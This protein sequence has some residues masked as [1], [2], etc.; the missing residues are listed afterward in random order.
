MRLD[1]GQFTCDFCSTI[2]A[3]D[4]H[5]MTDRYTLP[6]APC[7]VL[8]FHM[9]RDNIDYPLRASPGAAGFDVE[10]PDTVILP[11]CGVTTYVPLGFRCDAIPTG[12]CLLMMGRSRMVRQQ[13]S[14]LV[15]GV[16]DNDYREEVFAM[17]TNLGA[18]DVT[19]SAGKKLIQMLL[20]PVVTRNGRYNG[21][22]RISF[23]HAAI[24]EE[25]ADDDARSDGGTTVDMVIVEDTPVI[26]VYDTT[27]DNEVKIINEEA[28][29]VNEVKEDDDIDRPAVVTVV[30]SDEEK[31][32]DE[33]DYFIEALDPDCDDGQAERDYAAWC[34]G[35][36]KESVDIANDMDKLHVELAPGGAAKANAAEDEM[37]RCELIHLKAR[38]DE[39]KK[40][41]AVILARKRH[42]AR[43]LRMSCRM[44][45][46]AAMAVKTGASSSSSSS[47]SSPKPSSS[48]TTMETDLI[49]MHKETPQ[50]PDVTCASAHAQLPKTLKQ[51]WDAPMF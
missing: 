23:D 36:M 6:S 27:N 4:D 3:P 51:L 42:A 11:G 12:H 5:N 1:C 38:E 10:F 19:L 47:S 35:T 7:D 37:D 32:D 40:K 9:L 20:T 25:E 29:D 17:V 22:V 31:T 39:G 14:L 15:R 43:L 13:P 48:A 44:K 30:D 33:N 21:R 41:I 49:R 16:I 28:V 2:S 8:H 34:A 24:D 26:E 46:V 50:G 45:R 18:N